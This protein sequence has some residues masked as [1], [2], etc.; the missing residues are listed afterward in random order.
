MKAVDELC[1]VSRPPPVSFAVSPS[2]HHR[3]YIK[4]QQDEKINTNMSVPTVRF[5][6]ISR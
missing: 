5:R 6:L 1:P 2:G 4:L 3:C